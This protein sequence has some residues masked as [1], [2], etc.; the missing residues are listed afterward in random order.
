MTAWYRRVGILLL[1]TLVTACSGGDDG[2]TSTLESDEASQVSS[3]SETVPENPPLEPMQTPVE[4]DFTALLLEDRRLMVEGESNLPPGA[5]LEVIVERERSGVRW[6]SRTD[7]GEGSFSAGPF[8][9]GSGLAD[10][11]Y[12][13]SVQLTESA[14]QPKAVREQ[15]GEQGQHLSGP[16]VRTSRH[17]LGKVAGHAQ[18]FMVGDEPRRTH[19][20]VN[21]VEMEE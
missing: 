7:M 2:E 17:G 21:V 19:D 15:I 13:I 3:R 11:G 8:G 20:Q 5:Q 6:R 14:V 4:I 12:L 10:G 1:V 18:R 16:L 9:P